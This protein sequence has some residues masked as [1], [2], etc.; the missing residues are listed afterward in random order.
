VPQKR[1][2]GKPHEQGKSCEKKIRIEEEEVKRR[3]KKNGR[4]KKERYNYE[5]RK[6]GEENAV[7]RD[8]MGVLER[9]KG[10]QRKRRR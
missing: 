9:V 1:N 5:R 4:G 10:E 7:G 2:G 8:T 6:H 3:R